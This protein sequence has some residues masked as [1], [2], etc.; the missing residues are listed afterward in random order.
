MQLESLPRIPYCV[1]R[2]G[3]DHIYIA[4][5]LSLRSDYFSRS[6]ARTGVIE[7]GAI[8]RGCGFLFVLWAPMLTLAVAQDSEVIPHQVFTPREGLPGDYVNSMAQTADGLLWIGTSSGLA[9]FDGLRFRELTFPES[10]GRVG[11]TSLALAA[12]NSLWVTTSRHGVWQVSGNLRLRKIAA[13][14]DESIQTVLTAGSTTYFL[15]YKHVWA[16]DGPSGPA[17][18]L[19]YSYEITT[20]AIARASYDGAG[21]GPATAIVAPDG[22]IV[23]LD[24]VLGPRVFDPGGTSVVGPEHR[25]A[26]TSIDVDAKGRL[27]ALD[28]DRGLF[29]LDENLHPELV[30]A[31]SGNHH[32]LIEG[33]IAYIAARSGVNRFDIA[34]GRQLESL[35]RSVGLRTSDAR[36]SFVDQEGSLWIS[37]RSHLIY[38]PKS[39]VRHVKY[40]QDER[41]LNVEIMAPAFDGGLWASSYGGG[42]TRLAP[43]PLMEKP[44]ESNL[45]TSVTASPDG[46]LFAIGNHGVARLQ[47]GR[48][49]PVLP[50]PDAVR[51]VAGAGETVYLWKGYGAFRYSLRDGARI[52]L[53]SWPVDERSYHAIGAT[54]DGGV[55]IRAHA[56]VLRA[57]VDESTSTVRLDTLGRLEGAERLGGRYLIQDHTGAVWIGFWDQGLVRMS[58]GVVKTVLPSVNVQQLSL[59]GD[60]L[61]LASTMTGLYAFD[62]STRRLMFSLHQDDGLISNATT[63]AAFL[64]GVLFVAHATGVSKTA[65]RTARAATGNSTTRS[66]HAGR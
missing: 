25:G 7:M 16:L 55:V 17:H 59:S 23:I 1:S 3:Y 64:D 52:E 66:S 11:V 37:T 48:W 50:V 19:S 30:Y 13:L 21:T 29:S 6:L 38:I 39:R 44:F 58:G 10:V 24:G 36:L 46:Q 45:W 62:V 47:Q 8:I 41:L 9:Y 26:W 27:W 32:L 60:S 5:F 28:Y 42:I 65:L 22:R 51:G 12:D 31:S 54:P 53:Y 20:P 35:D 40:G 14:G 61:L 2:R 49:Q 15:Q 57:V 33:G 63:G 34:A 18:K 4:P 43:T 56:L